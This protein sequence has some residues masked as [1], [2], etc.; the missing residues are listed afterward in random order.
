[1]RTIPFVWDRRVRMWTGLLLLL[2]C[3][4]FGLSHRYDAAGRLTWSVQP[5]GHATHFAYD[6]AGNITTILVVTPAQD[7]DADGLPDTW[8]IR[9]SA[10]ETGRTATA[11]PDAD[12]LV[13][14]QEF[15]FTR[16]PDRADGANLTP[17]SLEAAGG[18]TRLTLPGDRSRGRRHSTYLAEVS[19]DLKTWSSAATDVEQLAPVSQGGGVE[20][21][22]VRGTA[23]PRQHAAPVPAHPFAKR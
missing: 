10:S 19:A 6:P 20:Q 3:T 11:D 8:E 9:Y 16:Q 17:V 21:V 5:G 4:A 13:D 2:P 14:L 23:A 22:T 18:G 1:M 12:G 15:A 7:S